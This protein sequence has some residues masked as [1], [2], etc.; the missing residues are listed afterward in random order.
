MIVRTVL[1]A[2]KPFSIASLLTTYI[3]GA[4]LVQYLRNF[5]GLGDFLQGGLF[6]LFIVIGFELM[7]INQML[8]DARNWPTDS[9]PSEVRR[10]RWVIALIVA[11]LMTVSVTIFI[12]WMIRDVM[13][14][15]LIFLVVGFIITC[16]I[17][18]IS[19]YNQ[20]FRPYKILVEVFLFVVIPP[21][22]AF[23]I[24][25]S[26]P[27]RLLTLVVVGLIPA[28]LAYRLL[29]QL[30]FYNN[31]LRSGTITLAAQIGWEKAMVTHNAL[32]LLSYFLFAL[33]ALIGFPWFLLWPVFL[34]LPIGLVEIWLM[35]K[36]RHGSKP[37]WRLMQFATAS[38]FFIP[39]YLLGFAFWIR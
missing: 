26:E 12:D 20:T 7:G 18:F 17:Y 24:Q 28:F 23:F 30:K 4:G 29:V 11:T 27:H 6:L 14:Q 1:K 16:A 10:A 19:E 21:A 38:V 35:E 37:F 34:T 31:D 32:I 8:R 25:S 2:F 13:W 39:M 15:G 9:S 3:L 22:F 5:R 36:V 33:D